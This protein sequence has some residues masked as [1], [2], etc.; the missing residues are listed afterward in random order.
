MLS[1]ARS[2]LVKQEHQVESLNTRTS[3]L[4]QQTYA[5]RLELEDAQHGY[6]ETR[7]EQVRLQEELSMK[8]K[9]LRNWNWRTPIT[10]I[11]NLEENNLAYK[12][13]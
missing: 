11:L 1:Q 9:V 3:E 7:R 4:Q 2:E 5:E 8:E 6:V 10:D 12:K 13:N